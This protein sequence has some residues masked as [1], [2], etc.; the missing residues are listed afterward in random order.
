MNSEKRWLTIEDLTQLLLISA[1][2]QYEL[3]RKKQIPYSKMGQ[4][5]V[6]DRFRIDKWLEGLAVC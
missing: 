2:K 5:I 6:Y 3:R 1:A 4:R